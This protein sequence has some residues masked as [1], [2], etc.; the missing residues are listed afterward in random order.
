MVLAIL[1]GSIFVVTPYA[2]YK[3]LAGGDLHLIGAMLLLGLAV[4]IICRLRIDP[5]LRLLTSLDTHW[6][7]ALALG[8]VLMLLYGMS[9]ALSLLLTFPTPPAPL[10][11]NLRGVALLSIGSV[12]FAVMWGCLCIFASTEAILKALQSP[13]APQPADTE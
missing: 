9:N 5:R 13:K 7:T 4:D 12:V 3:V 8:F 2:F 10:G 1:I 6:I 11:W